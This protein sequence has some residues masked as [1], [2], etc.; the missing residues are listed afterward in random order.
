MSGF[1]SRACYLSESTLL[2]LRDIGFE[3]DDLPLFAA[4]S[5]ALNSGELLQVLG[6]NGSGKTTLLRIIATSLQP[7]AG[8]LLWQG[9]PVARNRLNYL[10][11]MLFI[12]HHTGVKPALTPRENLQWWCSLQGISGDASALQ[13]IG[14]LGYEDTPCYQLSAGQLRR[15]ALARLIVSPAKLWVLDEPFTAIDI[16]GVQLL[17]QLMVAH[18]SRGGAVIL[19][20]HQQTAMSNVRQLN[21][22]DCKPANLVGAA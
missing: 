15:V 2:T 11:Q 20:S 3:R 17:E 9:K 6:E 8:E 22:A 14:L 13:K 10:S 12:G 7:T 1:S 21:L 4:V 16:N 18:T 19:S 5:V